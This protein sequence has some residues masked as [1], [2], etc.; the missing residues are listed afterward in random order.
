[1][2]ANSRQDSQFQ[3]IGVS[4]SEPTQQVLKQGQ[5]RVLN[6]EG[7]PQSVIFWSDG[8][9]TQAVAVLHP[10]LRAQYPGKMAVA[11]FD[12]Y[13]SGVTPIPEFEEPSRY[14]G[15]GMRGDNLQLVDVPSAGQMPV[16]DVLLASS[17]PSVTIAA[18]GADTDS[19]V[20]R[21]VDAAHAEN[22]DAL[23]PADMLDEFEQDCK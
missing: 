5:E 12:R 7:E 16:V 9:V 8:M 13:S 2:W 4:T 21:K 20:Q 19:C 23:I 14:P 1:V 15:A 22:P 11:G 3:G 6:D 18:A 10:T 17:E